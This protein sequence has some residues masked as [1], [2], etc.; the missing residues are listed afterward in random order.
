MKYMSQKLKFEEE[1][2]KSA[3]VISRGLVTSLITR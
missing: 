2:S 1:M 3:L